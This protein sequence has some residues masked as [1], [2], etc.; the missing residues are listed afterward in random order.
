MFFQLKN[1]LAWA[2]LLS[3]VFGCG[4]SDRNNTRAADTTSKE[5]VNPVFEPVLADP[6]VVRDPKSKLFYAFG[7]ADNWGDEK[8]TRWVP[9]LVS[10]D[11]TEWKYVK[12]ALKGRPT[13]KKKGG[14]WAPDVN[15]VDGKYYMYYAFSTWGDPNP[16][17]GLAIADS[18]HGDF[19]DQGKV[20][21][22]EEVNVPNSIDPCF[23]EDGSKKYL[24]WG[25]FSDLPTQGTYALELTSDGKS[26]VDLNQK[27]K[28]AAGDWEAV[29]IHKRGEYYYFFG[30]KGSCCEGINS[31]Y[32]VL[33]GRAKQV[34]G[35]YLDQDGQ[36]ITER[37]KGTLLLQGN[38]HFVG[39]GHNAQIVTDDEGADW[40]L[41][42]GFDIQ[43]GNLANGTNR[44]VLL[45]DQLTWE[46]DWPVIK[47][48]GASAGKQKAPVFH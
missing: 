42:H 2:V 32:H 6:T 30:S 14:V 8:G 9:M 43:D 39:T 48:Q 37:G 31:Q 19:V 17:I 25:S 10:Q 41:Y 3:S 12:D 28:I 27:T 46:N 40:L 23:F 29:M 4:A 21:L 11:L 38:D 33:V 18:L 34:L 15:Y 13:W 24:F 35:P 1:S 36:V 45:L 7:T 5:Y 16:G 20:F 47:N 22:S 44:R 26:A